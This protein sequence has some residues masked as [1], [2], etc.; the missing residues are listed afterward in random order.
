MYAIKIILATAL[1]AY[2]IKNICIGEDTQLVEIDVGSNIKNMKELKLSQFSREIHYIPLET[3]EDVVFSKVS[4][5]CDTKEYFVISDNSSLLLYDKSGYFQRR[6]GKKGRG[7]GE[8]Q[9]IRNL[10][11]TN[12][13]KI[14]LKSLYDLFVFDFNGTFLEKG[15]NIFRLSNGY[16]ISKFYM[17]NDSL[18]LCHIQNSTGKADIKACIINKK[19]IIKQSF[20]NYI[21]FNRIKEIAYSLEGEAFF[22][23]YSGELFYKDVYNDTIFRMNSKHQLVPEYVFTLGKYKEPLSERSKPLQETDPTKYI[24][25]NGIFQT[26][27]YFFLTYQFGQYFPAKRITPKILNLPTGEAIT[28]W[29]DTQ[30]VVGVVEK[31]SGNLVFSKPTSSDNRLFTTGFYNDID[32]GPRFIPDKILNDSTM[33]MFVEAKDLKYH[34]ESPDFR[35][36][37]PIYPAKKRE[38]EIKTNKIS[39]SDNPILMIVTLKK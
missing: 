33:V 26:S 16:Y 20:K 10:T 5:F 30:V 14:Y 35:K 38:L 18:L 2:S 15:T 6:I 17:L 37:V 32:G 31:A 12:D 1:L 27:K 11:V 36:S 19:G 4:D 24:Y 34:I 8:Y 22:Q 28:H 25:L 13:Y 21:T 3:R 7:P 39:E 29:Y 9:F 23:E